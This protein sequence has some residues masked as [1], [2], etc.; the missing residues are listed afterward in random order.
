MRETPDLIVLGGDYV[1]VKDPHYMHP[2]AEALAPLAAPHGVFGI[3]GNHDD[4]RDMPAALGKNGVQML[5]DARTRLTIKGETV[6]L[7]GHPLL[8]QTPVRH[9]RPDAGDGADDL[10]PG[11]RPA[12][13]H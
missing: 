7:V 12:P 11:A 8:D 1:T 4:D 2:S 3:L 13:A 6:D 9:R 10:P 5:K